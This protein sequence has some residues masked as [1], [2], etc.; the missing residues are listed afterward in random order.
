MYKH[1][2]TGWLMSHCHWYHLCLVMLC[3]LF[4]IYDAHV[5]GRQRRWRFICANQFS[6]AHACLLR[7]S[8]SASYAYIHARS[9]AVARTACCHPAGKHVWCGCPPGRKPTQSNK[10]RRRWSSADQM[11]GMQTVFLASTQVA[12]STCTPNVSASIYLD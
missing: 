2:R 1:S 3:R 10:R 7:H 8:R 12:L 11:A 9:G 5:S 4:L 6:P